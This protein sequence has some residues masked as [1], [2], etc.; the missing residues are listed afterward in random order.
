MTWPLSQDYNEAIQ[1]PGFAFSDPEMRQGV[2]ATNA[3]GL[4]MPRSGNFA[5]VYEL[6]CPKHKWAVKCFTREVPGLRDRYREISAY[7]RRLNLP[8]MVDFNY[9][10]EG[11]R[12]RGKW[13][14]VLKMHWIEGFTLN[15]FVRDALGKPQ[16]LEAVSQI[17]VRLSRRLRE[18]K[19]AHCDLQHGNVLLVPGAKASALT[20]K[21][22]DYDGMFVPALA[23]QRSG[24]V[25]HPA[26]QHPE[27]LRE[28]TYSAEVDRF[29]HLVIYCA[30]RGLIAGGRPL[31]DRYDNGD[32]LLFRQSDLASP[33]DSALFDELRRLDDP[34]VRRLVATLSLAARQPLQQT[35]LLENLVPNGH[36]T[37]V[38]ISA[39]R[40]K[41]LA[42]GSEQAGGQS[43]FAQAETP[44]AILAAASALDE[45][46]AKRRPAGARPKNASLAWSLVACLGGLVALLTA[47]IVI[48]L[49]RGKGEQPTVAAAAGQEQTASDP[50]NPPAAGP[51][52]QPKPPDLVPAQ[53][54]PQDNSPALRPVSAKIDLQHPP[55][56]DK[57]ATA[58]VQTKTKWVGGGYGGGGFGP[59]DDAR[60]RDF[61]IGFDLHPAKSANDGEYFA[62]IAPVYLESKHALEPA[63]GKATLPRRR[64]MAKEGYAVGGIVAEA[65]GKVSGFQITFMRID[66]DRLNRRDAYDSPWL[67]AH[68]HGGQR[69][70]M[71]GDGNPVVGIY[72]SCQQDLDRL[73]LIQLGRRLPVPDGPAMRQAEKEIRARCKE[74][75]TRPAPPGQR[76]LAATLLHEAARAR[77]SAT[78]HLLLGE[79]SILAAGGGDLRRAM[80]T[81]DL[82]S[83]EEI[84]WSPLE[85]K[86]TALE[87]VAQAMEQEAAG[88]A[89]KPNYPALLAAALPLIDEA[90]ATHD[91]GAARHLLTGAHAAAQK[92]KDEAMINW[93]QIR[94]TEV[95]QIV[96]ASKRGPTVAKPEPQPPEGAGG[97]Q[98]TARAGAKELFTL[99][100]HR[101]TI[102]SVAVAPDGRTALSGG[103]D[104]T[105]RI[106]NL[107]TRKEVGTTADCPW[108]R[109]LA[110]HPDGKQVVCGS[111]DGS[112]R[113]WR[114]RQ[115]R[116][117]LVREFQRTGSSV[118]ADF[119][120]GSRILSVHAANQVRF[121][122]LLEG[123]SNDISIYTGPQWLQEIDSLAVSADRRYA[124]LGIS[125]SSA[126]LWDIATRRDLRYF[127]G[128]SGS[129]KAVALSR[130]SRRAVTAGTGPTILWNLKTGKEVHHLKGHTGDVWSVAFSRDS[131]RILSGGADK[132]VRLWDARTGA[133]I[134]RF[135]GHEGGVQSVAFTPD[136]RRALSGS[137][138]K[139]LRLWPLPKLDD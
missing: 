33:G 35:P 118:I 27:R 89:Q 42:A 16:V 126:L 122:S 133:E 84:I 72:G 29:P 115:G 73:G 104:N 128:P 50:R 21:L 110:F 4:P 9:L 134:R 137:E 6:R 40:L 106:W 55:W 60:P 87:S 46:V 132:T 34:E 91:F 125:D 82:M 121:C 18:A 107:E 22:I 39:K 48:L 96:N 80:Q 45:P 111:M 54:R 62:G 75:F 86:A 12:I 71:G 109:S 20:V 136:N 43:A 24:E 68:A 69:V 76:A 100:G 113:L 105:I 116:L 114:L 129:I 5:D 25:G 124:L 66:G 13:Y 51:K 131:R 37:A 30:L 36:A 77:D 32:N 85:F 64:L 31:W 119:V 23:R 63:H 94:L 67:G 117:T 10:D 123:A 2:P 101:D 49:N 26:F 8:F 127:R 78:R 120:V 70:Q 97:T 103:A 65:F 17:W 58:T 83:E 15:E 59:F 130:D 41:A 61:L 135:E 52:E 1:D 47:A 102:L 98:T 3:L 88:G 7:L 14:P 57:L 28:G 74:A 139:T 112:I 108:P 53:P 95:D 138:D 99:Q 92:G 44:D 38:G 90:V 93:T 11:I 19:M 79:I 56:F 81:I